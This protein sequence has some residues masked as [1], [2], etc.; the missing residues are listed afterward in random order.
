MA[1]KYELTVSYSTENTVNPSA[2][3]TSTEYVL[4]LWDIDSSLNLSRVCADYYLL[5][6]LELDGLDEGQFTKMRDF[7]APQFA[8]YTDMVLGG[9]LRHA[10][11]YTTKALQTHIPTPIKVALH[12]TLSKHSRLDAWQAW[13]YLRETYGARALEWASQTFLLFKN[14]S[15]GGVPWSNI[16]KHLLEYETGTFGAS[17]FVD[18]CWGLQHNGG[19]YFNKVW[20]PPKNQV[21]DAKRE[22]EMTILVEFATPKIASFWK[23]KSPFEEVPNASEV[24]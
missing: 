22:S 14:G 23:D 9:E 6:D 19:S 8:A 5:L 20:K 12:T 15:F 10:L 1:G 17:V 21:L 16:A 18:F 13:F 2:S 11:G 7:L 4:E 3:Q 24:S